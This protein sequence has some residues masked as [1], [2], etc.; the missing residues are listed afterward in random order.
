MTTAPM[1]GRH[2][3]PTHAT[4]RDRAARALVAKSI[5]EFAHELLLAPHPDGGSCYVLDAPDGT[6]YRFRAHR[7]ALDHSVVV[8]ASIE[9]SRDGERLPVD[10]LDFI[11][12]FAG[13]LG[14][15]ADVLPVYLE[16]INSTLAAA[17][18]KLSRR[19]PGADD[20]VD[21]DFQTIEASMTEG[22]PAF[23]ANNGRIGFDPDDYRRFAPETGSRVRLVWIAVSRKHARLSLSASIN[24]DAFDDAEFTGLRR[25]MTEAGLD[26]RDYLPMPVHP[27]QWRKRIAT[28]FAA[29]VARRDIVYLG[30][31]THS[32]QPQQSIRTF[33]DVDAPDNCY[34]KTSLSIL[35]MGFMRGLSPT[36]MKSTPAIN[37]WLH[38]LLSG[39][40]EIARTGF[41]ILREIA[42]IGY[43]DPQYD[44]A[45]GRG[46]AY[47]KMLS[48]LWRESPI[49][50]L[51][52][53]ERPAT[54]TSLLHVDAGGKPFVSALIDRSGLNART[55]VERYLRA[56][57]RPLVHCFYFHRLV[58]MPHGENVILVLSGGVPVRV[59]MKDIGEE[60]AVL[61]ADADLPEGVE[62]IRA[63]VP[64]DQQA[65]SI[66]TDVFDSFFRFLGA[67]LAG[68]GRL[69]EDEFWEAVADCIA[70]YQRDR[71]DLARL[72]D[73]YDLFAPQF[74]RSC[75]NRLQLADNT[76]MVDLSDPA[77]A[78]KF[79]GV[80]NNP[81]SGFRPPRTP[82]TTD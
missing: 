3:V 2:D 22:H 71:P 8:P 15:G 54:M 77:G 27:W 81:I 9:R 73:A 21:T 46:S 74:A 45:A 51:G 18:Y 29:A 49:P 10:A 5:G 20:L 47:H 50:R 80:L 34:V 69:G 48:A 58:F 57:L 75:L 33:F 35:N 79:A 72:F 41:S 25:R 82:P 42:A 28:T 63:D 23:V 76:Q 13:E 11:I 17:A 70:D 62:R 44:R 26:P 67:T 31:G 53:G 65:L 55:W 52:P 7:Y 30:L 61:D 68:D 40:A 59:L 43:T 64:A 78:L 4:V 56:Y 16:E 60:I 19:S 32:Y 14:I 66:F 36:Y 6:R 12:E 39:D 1:T 37:D 24:A 38:A